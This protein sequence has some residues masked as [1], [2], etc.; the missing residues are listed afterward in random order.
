M[1][2]ILRIWKGQNDRNIGYGSVCTK[3][4]A[5][6]FSRGYELKKIWK[7]KVPKSSVINGRLVATVMSINV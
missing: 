3:A 4:G 6:N 5:Y 1:C 2:V 7:V